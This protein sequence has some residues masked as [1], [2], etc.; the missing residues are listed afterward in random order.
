MLSSSNS[1]AARLQDAPSA[2]PARAGAFVRHQETAGFAVV[3]LLLFLVPIFFVP[4]SVAFLGTVTPEVQFFKHVLLR[5]LCSVLFVLAAVRLFTLD[6]RALRGAALGYVFLALLLLTSLLSILLSRDAAY[7]LRE[8]FS[9]GALMIAAACAPLFVTTPRRV[10]LLLLAATLSATIVA[11]VALLSVA[12]FTGIY[13]FIYGADPVAIARAGM[14]ELMGTVEGGARRAATMSTLGNPE[15][16]GT[17]TAGGLLLAGCWLLDGFG[18]RRLQSLPA[19][20]AGMACFAILAVAMLATQTRTALIVVIAGLV[21]RWLAGLPI[22]GWIIG[23]WLLVVLAC[24]FAFGFAA[25]LIV[26]AGGLLAAFAWQLA[27][28][29]FLPYWKSIPLRS[30]VLLA[31]VP[32]VVVLVLVLAIFWDPLRFR[33]VAVLDRVL[34]A[35]TTQDRSVRERLIFYMMAGEMTAGR[36]L[37]GVGPGFFPAF[38]HETLARLAASDPTGVM[39]YNQVQLGEWVALQTHNDFFQIAAERGL[40]GLALFLGLGTA[41]VSGLVRLVRQPH[42]DLG[43]PAHALAVV[44]CGYLAMMLT[45][46]PLHEAARLTTFYVLVGSALAVLALRDQAP[47]PDRP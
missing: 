22:R 41:L 44:L 38:Y 43:P 15:F 35:F 30:R 32:V 42:P 2:T 1:P 23:V 21:V 39:A 46:F 4:P 12:G 6:L 25:M 33:L 16:A 11:L 40:A 7:S 3:F 14:A 34:S 9:Q 29:R 13:V 28:H 10:R 19:W 5:L 18:S 26:F 37:F 45:A 8:F 17:F 20:I 47:A 31:A 24:A 27:T 36:P